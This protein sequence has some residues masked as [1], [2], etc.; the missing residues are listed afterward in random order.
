MLQ[1]P[2]KAPGDRV[3]YPIDFKNLMASGALIVAATSVV[4]AGL[5]EEHPAGSPPFSGTI[6]TPVFSGGEEGETYQFTLQVTTDSGSP[7]R[8]FERAFCVPVRAL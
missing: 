1:L 7:A 4:D 8:Q 6:V 5:V 2:P 3:D